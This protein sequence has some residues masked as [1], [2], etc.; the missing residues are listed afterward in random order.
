MVSINR[1]LEKFGLFFVFFPL[2][3][4][5]P[6]VTDLYSKKTSTDLSTYSA[7]I[8]VLFRGIA[9]RSQFKTVF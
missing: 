3:L 5:F 9:T 1:N 6:T 2:C 7:M 4:S 8:L